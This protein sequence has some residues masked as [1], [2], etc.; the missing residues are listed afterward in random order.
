MIQPIQV[1]PLEAAPTLLVLKDQ[2]PTVFVVTV[3][4]PNGLPAL[5]DDAELVHPPVADPGVE[6]ELKMEVLHRAGVRLAGLG[7]GSRAVGPG[8][9]RDVPG[10]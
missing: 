7:A 4:L 6:I 1:K 9:L 8:D 3:Q 2:N 5:V 10:C